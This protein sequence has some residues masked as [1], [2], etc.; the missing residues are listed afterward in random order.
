LNVSAF[1]PE[2][3]RNTRIQ[4]RRGRMLAT[5]VICLAISLSSA[6]FYLYSRTGRP[7]ID[8][9]RGLF[10]VILTLQIVALLIGGGIYCLQSVHREKD[11]NT[12]DYQ[13]ITRMSPLQLSVGK[14]LGAPALPYFAVV[15]LMPIA[16]WAAI[17]AHVPVSVFLQIYVLLVLG[18]ITYHALA[19]L[20]SLLLERGTS[21]GGI[22]FFL[23]VVGMS[24]IDFSQDG[25]AFAVHELSPFYV[26]K[27]LSPMTQGITRGVSDVW[28]LP[29]Q[30]DV[31][32]GL[33]VPHS[34]V[35]VVLYATLTAWF[36]LASVRNIK[37]DPSVY[38]VYSP[39][40]GFALVL[41][42]NLLL[43]GF[44]QW[45]VPHVDYVRSAD[46]SVVYRPILDYRS[47]PPNAAEGLFLSISLWFF[48]MLGLALLRNRDRVRR[49]IREYGAGAAG[50]WAAMWP[51]PYLVSGAV[52][53]GLGIVGMIR[54][55][56]QP[57]PEWNPGLGLLEAG[58]FALWIIRDLLYLQWMN[59][60][61]A[62]R[63][64]VTG[65]LYLIVFYICASTLFVPLGWYGPKGAPHAAISVP[66][67]A[68]QLDSVTWVSATSAWIAALILI[69][70]EAL[71]FAW[72]QW[73]ELQKLL[74][75]VPQS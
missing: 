34:W 31:F 23:A 62:R 39:M 26:F 17:L 56:L 75:I 20:I 60:R 50:W 36:L 27:L 51:A 41:Y 32:F 30:T 28:G 42:L 37:R 7:S 72:L 15:C 45:I 21:A 63:P 24:S 65:V 4:L 71:F 5:A 70:L 47:T 64:L 2:L 12:F 16:G 67:H 11:L 66:F 46:P 10:Q 43:L 1:N 73:R 38:E 54:L 57:Q 3:V 35:L 18:S 53:A 55:R 13:R 68:F 6:A 61:R 48:V 19:L 74:T 25:S 69:L 44:F 8:D 40:Q 33:Q 29:N 49:R 58:F 59:L 22:L 9:A 52:L 14:L